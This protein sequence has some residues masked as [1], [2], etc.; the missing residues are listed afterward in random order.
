MMVLNKLTFQRKYKVVQIWPGQ[1]VTCLHTISPGHIGT[2]LYISWSSWSS[3]CMRF[4]TV[5]CNGG[6]R[7]VVWD[8]RLVTITKISR[9]NT[10]V[11]TIGRTEDYGSSGSLL[12]E[13]CNYNTGCFR[14]YLDKRVKISVSKRWHCFTQTCVYVCVSEWVSEWV[15]VVLHRLKCRVSSKRFERIW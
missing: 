6:T 8:K 5:R 15:S 10:D 4:G 11:C 9:R 13:R 12:K 7:I 14:L 3:K 1:T 2:T